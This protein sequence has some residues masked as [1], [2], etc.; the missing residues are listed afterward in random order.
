[1]R[2]GAASCQRE[3]FSHRTLNGEPVSQRFVSKVAC[4]PV[5]KV[6]FDGT[7]A[8]ETS[9]QRIAKLNIQSWFG[10]PVATLT[11]LLRLLDRRPMLVHD[12][13]R[14]GLT[15][16]MPLGAHPAE[17]MLLCNLSSSVGDD[18]EGGQG[19]GVGES[20]PTPMG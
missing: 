16:Q 10:S 17:S 15:M 18:S 19:E 9:I 20:G 12:A 11:N 6:D 8:R 5:A 2:L 13:T 1:M 4:D 3:Q 14:C 7:V